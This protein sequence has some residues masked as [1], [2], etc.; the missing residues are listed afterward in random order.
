VSSE[1]PTTSRTIRDREEEAGEQPLRST[2]DRAEAEEHLDRWDSTAEWASSVKTRM[3][4]TA[5][6]PRSTS[7]GGTLDT[8][9]ASYGGSLQRDPKPV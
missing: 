9:T 1:V 8:V 7:R 4:E 2:Q 5:R 6:T 3:T